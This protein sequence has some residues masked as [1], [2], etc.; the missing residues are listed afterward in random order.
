MRK[1]ELPLKNVDTREEA[2]RRSISAEKLACDFLPPILSLRHSAYITV[3]VAERVRN[4]S[5][6]RAEYVVDLAG[7]VRTVL[8]L[9]SDYDTLCDKRLVHKV[10]HSFVFT[11]SS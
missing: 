5:L 11:S 10:D 3:D 6:S 4:T 7:R 2:S 8:N 1:N 9:C